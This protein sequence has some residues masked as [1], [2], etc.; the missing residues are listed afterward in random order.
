MTPTI[1][2]GGLPAK[3]LF[4]GI[5]PGLTG[6]YQIDFQVPAGITGDDVPVVFSMGSSPTDTRT[7]SIQRPR[8][9]RPYF[10][11]SP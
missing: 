5:T 7:M 6:E 11:P 3:I 1:T 2:V 4:S 10:A 9:H 8:R